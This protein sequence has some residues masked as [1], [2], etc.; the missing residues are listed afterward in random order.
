VGD[1]SD[2][3]ASTF[4]RSV[5]W[6]GRPS[7][8]DLWLIEQLFLRDRRETDIATQIGIT[9]QAI[10]KRKWIILL[11]LRRYMAGTLS[12]QRDVFS[13]HI[14]SG[15]PTLAKPDALTAKK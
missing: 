7:K 13:P 6:L 9:Q 15:N 2:V 3:E 5:S 4:M 14:D 1:Q 8:P 11:R 12:Q 10:S